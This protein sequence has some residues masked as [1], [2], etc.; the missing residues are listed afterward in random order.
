MKTRFKSFFSILLVAAFFINYLNLPVAVAQPQSKSTAMD[1]NLVLYKYDGT[2]KGA[3]IT[4]NELVVGEK[5]LAVV[6]IDN[7]QGFAPSG[8]FSLT[9]AIRYD[10]SVLK[11]LLYTTEPTGT[12]GTPVPNLTTSILGRTIDPK[13]IKAAYTTGATDSGID[14][15]Q[16]KVIATYLYNETTFNAANVVSGNAKFATLAVP[17]EVKNKPASG[18]TSITLMTGTPD[19][20]ATII[21][22]V[23]AGAPVTAN[24]VATD[25]TPDITIGIKT[26]GIQDLTVSPP[27]GIT[28]TVTSAGVRTVTVKNLKGFAHVPSGTVVNV[29]A[30]DGTTVLGTATTTADG[31]AVITLDRGTDVAK[32]ALLNLGGEYRVSAK[33]GTNAESEKIVHKV[34]K[35]PNEITA[36]VA[37]P[38]GP[39]IFVG[40]ALDKF[41]ASVDAPVTYNPTTGSETV[42]LTI[43]LD[44]E[45]WDFVNANNNASAAGTNKPVA[46]SFKIAGHPDNIANTAGH[47][48]T[49]TVDVLA[50]DALLP[51]PDVADTAD[52]PKNTLGTLTDMLPTV[53]K[54]TSG[55][56]TVDVTGVRWTYVPT[57]SGSTLNADFNI[58]GAEYN[59]TSNV[60]DANGNKA[61]VKLIVNKVIGR[62]PMVPSSVEIV[63][64]TSVD[65]F[66]VLQANHL[67][68]KG[69]LDLTNNRHQPTSGYVFTWNPN[70]LPADF[71]TATIG[72]SWTFE[73]TA[74]AVDPWVTFEGNNVAR[75][76]VD[77]VGEP[78]GGGVIGGGSP[79]TRDN[80]IVAVVFII[81]LMAIVALFVLN[82]RKQKLSS[83]D[84]NIS[85]VEI[86]NE[87]NKN[88]ENFNS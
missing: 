26:M 28:D 3:Q 48:A 20:Q 66:D 54:G 45:T 24:K 73:G 19:L 21:E 32:H 72:K 14:A 5:F 44:L 52:N 17:F 83:V 36:A 70:T 85:E 79:T 38:K 31:P 53:I 42:D 29:Y 33:Q 71:S 49:S 7:L 22:S 88:D 58:K 67:P 23:N 65:S 57:V 37:V 15:V 1:I 10:S 75:V 60:Q 43:K 69:N 63:V 25:I 50:L 8:L 64:G 34:V 11:N 74:A 78:S 39:S 82:K 41:P 51:V 30:P 16:R 47:R 12:T 84:G 80:S 81:F 61:S 87:N 9:N 68:T 77:I 56:A 35:R 27:E 4:G 76:I 59:F 62:L 40:A 46:S 2:N 55:G 6:E 18:N 86:L 13:L